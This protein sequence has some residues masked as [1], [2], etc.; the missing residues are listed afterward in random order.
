[1]KNLVIFPILFFFSFTSISQVQLGK[2]IDA[3][4]VGDNSGHSVSLS[5]DGSIM[6]IGANQ[7]KGNGESS[8]HVRVYKDSSDT[9]IQIGAEIDGE[10]AGDQSGISV[11][12]SSNGSVLAIG[13]SGNDGNE[14]DIQWNSGQVRI[15]KYLSGTWTQIGKDIDGEN[16][17]DRSGASV[18]LSSDGS[19]VAIGAYSN[20]GSSNDVHW[21]SGHVRIYQNQSDTWA[22]LGQDIDGEAA[23]DQSGSSVSLSSDG[24]VVAIGAKNNAGNGIYSGQVRVYKNLSG[25][26][27]QIGMDI[28]G[29][30]P[31]DYSGSSVSL[32]SDG[33][34]VAIGAIGNDGNGFYSGQVRVYKNLSGTW[35]QVGKD[36][37]GEAEKDQSGFSVSLSSDGSVVAIGATLNDGN[38]TDAGQVRIYKNL[39][40]TW[41]RLGKDINGEAINDQSGFSVSLSSDGSIVAIGAPLNDGLWL[42]SGHA[43]VYKTCG[44]LHSISQN[45]SNVTMTIGQTAILGLKSDYKFY[46]WQTDIGSGFKNIKDTGQFDGTETD[47]LSIMQLSYSNNY[48]AFRCLVSAENCPDTSRV[49]VLKVVWNIGIRETKSEFTV[50]PNPT[51]NELKI[52]MESILLGSKFSIVNALG[53]EVK[54]GELT[55]TMSNIDVSKLPK[56][57]YVMCI[58]DESYSYKFLVQ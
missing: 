20:D 53:Q 6:A 32:S 35:T 49:A 55:S 57:Y 14:N 23:R 13:A 11:S 2:D 19:I 5:S 18:S 28:D 12:L 40:G 33:R 48:Q 43:R 27:T 36:I 34:I 50:Y 46:Q 41:A 1:M 31:G 37:D 26:W 7:N 21:N 10:F 39:S 29:E 52:K 4:S 45:P 44:E 9:W 47:K 42:N 22:Q 17:G 16:S 58:G 30:T 24:S 3:E 15:Y 25:T 51:S 38:G 8:G 56:G 54:K